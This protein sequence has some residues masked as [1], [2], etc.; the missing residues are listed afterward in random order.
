MNKKKSII[1]I[2]IIFAILISCFI[3]TYAADSGKLVLELNVGSATGKINGIASGV[4]KPYVANNVIMVPLTWF[5][6]AVGAEVNT[7]A[8]NVIEVVY[9][10]LYAEITIGSKEYKAG[11]ET[12]KLAVA[13]V[14]KNGRTMVPLEF[15]AKNFPVTVTSDIK[16]GTVKIVLEDDGALSDLSFLTGGITSPK[17]GNSYY[18]WSLSI[19]SGS[20]IISNSFKSDK[21]GITNESRSLYFEVSVENKDGRTLSELYNDISYG[22]TIRSSKIDLKADTPYFQ[23]TRLSEYDESLRVKVFDKG[24]YF[25]YL[26]INCYD[27]SVSPEKLVTDKY[28]DNIINSFSL[29]YKGNTKGVEDLSKVEDG[30]VN[31]YNY[32]VLNSDTKYLP[33]AINIPAAWNQFMI[34][35][36]LLTTTLG[37]DSTHCMKITMNTLG[38]EYGDL[39]GYV[40]AVTDKYD[41]FF[42]PKLYTFIGDDYITVAGTEA[43]ILDFSIKQGDKTYII[44]ELYFIKN[45]IVY[46]IS[47]KLPE[48]EHDRLEQQFIDT[49]D[50]MTF[51]SVNEANYKSDMEKY[52]ARNEGVRVSEEDGVFTYVNKSYKWKLDI[53]GYW[54]KS[55]SDDSS[56]S[57]SNPDTGS[58]VLIYSLENTSYLKNL[59]DEDKFLIMQLL[60]KTYDVKPVKGTAYAKGYEMRTYTYR[61]ENADDD[62][63]ATITCYCFEAGNNSYC[64]IEVAPDLGATDA[65]VKENSGIWNSFTITN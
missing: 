6:T 52:K 41:K 50:Q 39:D 55:S 13:P 25:Y 44:D 43:R 47:I 19:P 15:I 35:D 28:Y 59:S 30:K 56:V 4:E 62:F 20:R 65:S 1:S 24:S 32:V 49:V 23:Y 34:Y 57:F 22:S 16:K 40:D 37:I 36:D 17:V 8:G 3:N 33:W 38:E 12:G 54:T 48:S 64:Y 58:A 11:S 60:G 31:F 45:G 27:S 7:K 5:T 42:N 63:F 46:E 26:T 29:N 18:G 14:V 21:I 2:F 9:Q 61:V 10:E 53:P 51:Y